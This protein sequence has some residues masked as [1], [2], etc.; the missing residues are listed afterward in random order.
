MQSR[1]WQGEQ[2]TRGPK[3]RNKQ[4]GCD[5]S[6]DVQDKGPGTLSWLCLSGLYGAGKAEKE[7][8]GRSLWL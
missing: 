1:A 2:G 4:L 8:P 3:G 7:G 5:Y 6:F